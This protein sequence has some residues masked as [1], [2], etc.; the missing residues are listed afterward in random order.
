MIENLREIPEVKEIECVTG[1]YDIL[2]KVEASTIE[3]LHEV[4]T[5]NI[6]KIKDV[7]ST[8][9]LKINEEVTDCKDDNS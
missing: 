9:T 1:P 6:R 4:V 7:R 5:W 8:Y 3:K 2:V